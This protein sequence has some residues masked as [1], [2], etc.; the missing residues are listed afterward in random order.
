[1]C[2][3]K[4]SVDLSFKEAIAQGDVAA[5]QNLLDQN[6]LDLN[7]F[8]DF[9]PK[10]FRSPHTQSHVQ[11]VKLLAEY[12]VTMTR[13]VI[14]EIFSPDCGLHAKELV[15]NILSH[16]NSLKMMHMMTI[17]DELVKSK[18]LDESLA[19][20]IF[21]VLLDKGLPVNDFGGYDFHD[22][23]SLGAM[24]PLHHCITNG[25]SDFVSKSY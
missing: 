18:G 11:I 23:T 22:F 25:K 15:I 8:E 10:F 13:G 17:F 24:T 9:E 5:I 16:Q 4:P 14:H 12:G 3:K 21:K 6:S 20:E 19:L 7:C 2:S 1:M